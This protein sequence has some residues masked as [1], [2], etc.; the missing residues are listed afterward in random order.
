MTL[1]SIPASL[2]ITTLLAFCL[3][4]DAL[5]AKGDQKKGRGKPEAALL[6]K[7]DKDGNGTLDSTEAAPLQKQYAALA[8]LDTDKD[9]KLSDSELAAA[10]VG[11]A[12]AGKKKGGDQKK[13]GKKKGAKKNKAAQQNGGKKQ[14]KK[15]AGKK[16][17]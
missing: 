14:G 1:R 12:K 9:G 5:A 8:A 6:G 11:K 16:Q 10:K 15:K 13:A 2:A 3:P 4:A 7:F 17:A